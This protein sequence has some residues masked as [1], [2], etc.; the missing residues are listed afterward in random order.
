VPDHCF[1]APSPPG[2]TTAPGVVPHALGK[3]QG[4]QE[5]EHN[6]K[7]TRE[8]FTVQFK[9]TRPCR[10]F[11]KCAKGNACAFA[12][13]VQELRSGPD[14]T[15]SKMCAGWRD[16]RCKLLPSQ[17]RFA[18][19]PNELQNANRRIDL[20]EA[21]SAA[22]T[23]VQLDE[24]EAQSL[25]EGSSLEGH[26]PRLPRAEELASLRFGG[27]QD[28]LDLDPVK[29]PLPREVDWELFTDELTPRP[30]A[31]FQGLPNFFPAKLLSQPCQAAGREDAFKPSHNDDAVVDGP[32]Y[33]GC[34][35]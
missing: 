34:S 21:T 26:R 32:L 18:H 3:F 10:F 35:F 4:I 17:C 15:K 19:G 28:F 20:Y 14:F 30:P 25:S 24:E 2:L 22:T 31:S 23:A 9:K 13:G 12:H 8:N 11:P 6:D 33:F 27:V 7:L 16:G 1:A 5:Q 29:V